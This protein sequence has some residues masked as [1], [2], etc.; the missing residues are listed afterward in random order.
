MNEQTK[1]YG[2]V[3]NCNE[4]EQNRIL[5]FVQWIPIR[6]YQSGDDDISHR[7]P[8]LG[9][10]LSQLP[11]NPALKRSDKNFQRFISLTQLIIVIQYRHL[12]LLFVHN[13]HNQLSYYEEI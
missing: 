7:A 8:C 11:F 12:H 6:S 1:L 3:T 10:P 2:S 13:H 9:M 4:A 5:M